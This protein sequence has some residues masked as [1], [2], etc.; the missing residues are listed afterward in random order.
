MQT[1]KEISNKLT[2][3][4]TL[5]SQSKSAVSAPCPECNGQQY[6]HYDVP[7]EHPYFGRAF[8]CPVCNQ[9]T[10]DSLCGL[11][12]HERGIS[13]DHIRTEGRH[14]TQKA[15][16]AAQLFIEKPVGFFSIHG[17]FGNG[18]TT[19]LMAIVNALIAKGIEA[20][21]ITAASLLAHLRETFNEETKESDYDRL[22]QLARVPVLV[23][24]EMDKLR[25]TPYSRELQQE[26]VNY[27][28]R[29]AGV[30]GTVLAWNGGLDGLPFPAIVSRACEFTVIHNTDSDMRRII[31]DIS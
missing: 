5:Q 26:L 4:V 7:V 20:R 24:D 11:K 10:L 22:H 15:V 17:N 3:R 21:Y 9:A 23:I 1:I 25:D 27:R 12:A 16:W 30:L 6:F 18:K 14:G 2:Q 19:I 31:G 8:P 29:D 28:Y 13:L